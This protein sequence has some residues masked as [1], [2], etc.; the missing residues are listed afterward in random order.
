MFLSMQYFQLV[1]GYSPLSAAVRF[2]P[3]API[4]VIVSTRTPKLTERFGSKRVV[5]VG[6]LLVATG[7]LMF[8][9]LAIDTQYLYVL[10][11]IVPLVAGM[12][13]VMSP[14]TAAIMSAVPARRAGAG[15]AMNDATRELGSALGVAVLGSIAASHFTSA[16]EPFVAKLPPDAQAAASSSL[17]GALRTAAQ[18]PAAAGRALEVGADQAF[19]GGIH[20]AVTVGAVL[21]VIAAIAVLRYLP[22]RIAPEGPLHGALESAE[23]ALELGIG[24]VPPAFPDT[25]HADGELDELAE[26]EVDDK[27]R[28]P[29]TTRTT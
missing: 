19:I 14:M 3:M 17:S 24:G 11:C 6:M 5:A 29:A 4:M 20:L 26:A 18:L 23:E 27:R 8:R 10:A 22:A 9:G 25:V 2:L 7:L 16:L 12:A 15:S 28:E 13:L 1:L 21:A